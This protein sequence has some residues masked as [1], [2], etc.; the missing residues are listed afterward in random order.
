MT[1]GAQ[2]NLGDPA[3]LTTLA[4]LSEHYSRS[5]FNAELGQQLKAKTDLP[6]AFSPP[7]MTIAGGKGQPLS[8]A[9]I[10]GQ[11]SPALRH[12]RSHPAFA[13]DVQRRC[14]PSRREDLPEESATHPR[15]IWVTLAQFAF[16]L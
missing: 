2:R 8:A 14:P 1:G 11:D 6:L 3:A 15:S 4:H 7:T 16:Y 10:G 12:C 13:H 9:N 5:F